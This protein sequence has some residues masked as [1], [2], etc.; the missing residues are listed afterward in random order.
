MVSQRIKFGQP[1]RASVSISRHDVAVQP[2]EGALLSGF[3]KYR[4]TLAPSRRTDHRL[5]VAQYKLVS[6]VALIPEV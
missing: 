1:T 3:A 5:V 2:V 6:V 4:S